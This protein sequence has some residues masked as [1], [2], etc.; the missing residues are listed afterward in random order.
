ME[1][2]K[3]VIAIVPTAT[4]QV[5]PFPDPIIKNGISV[6]P[7]TFSNILFIDES[8]KKFFEVT[9]FCNADLITGNVKH[10]PDDSCIITVADFYNQYRGCPP[11]IR[12]RI[13]PYK[14]RIPVFCLQKKD[15]KSFAL[16]T[17][18]C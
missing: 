3:G 8:D 2:G 14:K 4:P 10:Y 7:E 1:S 11:L 15:C 17:I 18:Q 5:H 16:I 6:I 12:T 9:K 13:S